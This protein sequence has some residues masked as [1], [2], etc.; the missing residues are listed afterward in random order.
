VLGLGGDDKEEE[1]VM[2]EVEGDPE[3]PAGWE[4]D[5]GPDFDDGDEAALWLHCALR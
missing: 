1:E 5:S 2:S 3:D 4:E